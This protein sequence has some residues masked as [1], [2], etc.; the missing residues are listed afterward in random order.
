M[1][2]R[3]GFMYDQ[4]THTNTECD[5]EELEF[6][7]ETPKTHQQL[8]TNAKRQTEWG[9]HKADENDWKEMHMD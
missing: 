5:T 9:R 4:I 7:A 6:K 3:Y 2:R 8:T 1:S